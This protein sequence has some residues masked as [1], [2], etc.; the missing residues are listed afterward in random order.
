M[1]ETEKEPGE[2]PP[3]GYGVLGLCCQACLLGPCRLT[4]FGEDS[5]RGRCGDDRDR[6]VARNLLR[7]AILESIRPM[8]DL[9]EAILRNTSSSHSASSSKN[10]KPPLPLSREDESYSFLSLS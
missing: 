10:R 9:K 5:V 4:P 2:F 3:C 8:K 7:L 6:I 1:K